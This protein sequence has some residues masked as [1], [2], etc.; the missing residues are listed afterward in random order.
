MVKVVC[1]LDLESLILCC[2]RGSVLKVYLAGVVKKKS[3]TSDFRL[4]VMLG[5]YICVSG[6]CK[7]Q[8]SCVT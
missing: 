3:V 6:A 4:Q 8:L 2:L 5:G 7:L 1:P